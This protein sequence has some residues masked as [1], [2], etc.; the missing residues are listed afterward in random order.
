MLFISTS[1]LRST[2]LKY[3][4]KIIK[5]NIKNLAIKNN[6]SLREL[7]RLSDIEP[8][9]LNRLANGK[10]QRIEINHIKRIAESLDIVDMNEIISIENK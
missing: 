1:L 3:T 2:L 6:I 8:A 4:E 5:I 10:R 7:A 9:T